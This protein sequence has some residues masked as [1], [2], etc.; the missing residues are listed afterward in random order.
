MTPSA[1]LARAAGL[2]EDEVKVYVERGLLQRPRRRRSRSGDVGFTREH[3][4]RLRFIRRALDIGY[5]Q[6]D[7]A[8]LAA[9]VG[10]MTCRD[11]YDVTAQ[12]AQQAQDPEQIHSLYQLMETCPKIGGHSACPILWLLEGKEPADSSSRRSQDALP[13][14]K[15]RPSY[16]RTQLE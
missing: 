9:P 13:S 6:D 10:L 14:A 2:P 1:Q 4:E 5:N 11:V 8:K 15:N 7:I 16:A 3:V 12:R